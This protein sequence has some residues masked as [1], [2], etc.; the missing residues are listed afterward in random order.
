MIRMV[1]DKLIE[2]RMHG[3]IDLKIN[4]DSSGV[5]YTWSNGEAENHSIG[6]LF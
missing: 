1:D 6:N 4:S 3:D 2:A 5:S